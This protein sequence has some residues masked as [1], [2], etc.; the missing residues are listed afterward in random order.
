MVFRKRKFPYKKKGKKYVAKKRP[1]S[2][3]TI[4]RA[5]VDATR[6]IAL[7]Y[8]DNVNL[9]NS[10]VYNA[11]TSHV[12]SANSIFDP[13]VTGVG[14]QPMYRD[15]MFEYYNHAYCFASKLVVEFSLRSTAVTDRR[16]AVYR[17]ANTTTVTDMN[18]LG[19][20]PSAVIGNMSSRAVAPVKLSIGWSG[21]KT[22][23]HKIVG[24]KDHQQDAGTGPAEQTYFHIACAPYESIADAIPTLVSIKIEY[25]VMF[26]EPVYRSGS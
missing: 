13:D 6:A 1:T 14:H 17:R 2:K 24:H 21:K 25:Y 4:A 23:N 11:A 26:S 10:A 12:L 20:Q 3:M 15:Q 16:V 19:T 5:P 8:T 22:F 9:A 7:L 18:A